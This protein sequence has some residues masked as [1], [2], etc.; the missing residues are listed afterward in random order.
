M[1]ISEEELYNLPTVE[2]IHCCGGFIAKKFIVYRVAF[3]ACADLR[4]VETL[5]EGA[6]VGYTPKGMQLAQETLVNMNSR[7]FTLNVRMA[8]DLF[9]A[10]S[11]EKNSTLRHYTLYQPSDLHEC[12]LA[13][14]GLCCNSHNSSLPAIREKYSQHKNWVT[15]V[16]ELHDY[17]RRD[18]NIPFVVMHAY[19]GGKL[20]NIWN[21][22]IRVRPIGGGHLEMLSKDLF[23]VARWYVINN[24]EELLP[25]LR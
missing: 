16:N 18:L 2:Y 1:G 6:M 15:N 8:N 21:H 5:T 13:L 22:I 12:V 10:A 19:F 23:R 17:F 3:H 25:Y 24:C 20:G 14:C 7:R 11:G 9:L 4:N